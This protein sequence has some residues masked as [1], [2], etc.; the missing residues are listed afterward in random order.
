MQ[1]TQ[2]CRSRR[3]KTAKVIFL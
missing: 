1:S 3:T 2:C